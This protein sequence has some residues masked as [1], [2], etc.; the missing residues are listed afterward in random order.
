MV[1]ITSVEPTEE[2][3]KLLHSKVAQE[4]SAIGEEN[5]LKSD[6]TRL[7]N[8]TRGGNWMR[9]FLLHQDSEMDAA[10]KMAMDALK[11]RFEYKIDD[12]NPDMF[13][14]KF[15]SV[16][17]FFQ[18]GCDKDGC[19]IFVIKPKTRTDE[20]TDEL[21]KLLLYWFDRLERESEEKI[22]VFVEL[23]G[24]G[25]R[26]MDMDF[27][28]FLVSCLQE[29]YPYFLNYLIMF[30][31]PWILNAA[32]KVIKSWLPPKS[33]AVV[34]FLDPKSLPEYIAPDQALVEWGGNDAYTYRFI[35]EKT[36]IEATSANGLSALEEMRR[37]VH[38]ADGETGS[39]DTEISDAS[40]PGRISEGQLVK[41][42]PSD[43]ILFHREDNE[44]IGTIVLT[45]IATKPI[46]YKI[47]ITSPDKYSVRPSTGVLSTDANVTVAITV[48]A[49]YHTSSIVRDKFLVMAFE[50]D[51]NAANLSSAVLTDLWKSRSDT[52]QQFR[53]R[54]SVAAGD[55]SDQGFITS[56]SSASKP[57]DDVLKKLND[58]A[59]GQKRLESKLS[60]QKYFLILQFFLVLSLIIFTFKGQLIRQITDGTCP[61]P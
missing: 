42:K 39:M 44:T 6:L 19:R 5:F 60:Y 51:A 15:L 47:K 16:G 22:T 52:A 37:K 7:K 17:G 1:V 13:G 49:G 41:L 18:R 56:A 4:V 45:N 21:K 43:E 38:F 40:G 28:R 53:L 12:L 59:N 31:M 27:T 20:K 2:Q 58:I 23:T 50:L 29:Y 57:S 61:A 11:V 26:D 33:Q 36:Q 3:V 25:I 55:A 24:C 10:F 30:E 34:K 54:C 32:W 35:P 8:E 46:T 14:E 48:K 9:R